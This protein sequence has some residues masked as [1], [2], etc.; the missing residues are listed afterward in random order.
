MTVR[1]DVPI[2]IRR[3]YPDD[4]KR[5]KSL[6]RLDS[7]RLIPGDL[8]VAEADDELL[9]A[10]AID[11]DWAV[12]DP[13][14]RTAARV[15]LLQARAR[16]LRLSGRRQSGVVRRRA[17][18]MCPWAAPAVPA[19]VRLHDPDTLGAIV[20]FAMVSAFPGLRS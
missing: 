1:R 4:A 20:G 13:F 12:A 9:A 10:V 2:T 3:A 18:A 8:L 17:L 6:A 7:R 5:L 11:D 19:P 15:D 16:Q 14:Q